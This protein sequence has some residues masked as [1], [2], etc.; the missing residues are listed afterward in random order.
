VQD[1]VQAEQDQA[2]IG[3]PFVDHHHGVAYHT[4]GRENHLGDHNPGDYYSSHRYKGY[5]IQQI[6]KFGFGLQPGVEKV[7]G[8]AFE[9]GPVEGYMYQEQP[10]NTQTCDL[11]KL[12]SSFTRIN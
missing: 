8:D 1:Y 9:P 11:V 6:K 7:F 12:K 3:Y 4:L 10:A 5:P 2:G